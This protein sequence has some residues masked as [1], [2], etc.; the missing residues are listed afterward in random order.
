[1]KISKWEKGALA[2]T[3]LCVSFSAGWFAQ[4]LSQTGPYRVET[5]GGIGTEAEAE[6]VAPPS[7]SASEV[8]ELRIQ[9][10]K[11]SGGT[12]E[13]AESERPR[14]ILKFPA[15]SESP[16]PDG[17]VNINT[18]GREELMALPGIGEKRAEAII[19]DRERNGPFR[20]PEELTR[21]SGIGEGILAGL[22]DQITVE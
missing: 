21:V 6:T 17:K 22:I 12:A 2:L 18:A 3:A 9:S 14:I 4:G 10:G 19:K 11:G 7:P 1:M 13:S 8:I 20:Y 5:E 16:E 15:P